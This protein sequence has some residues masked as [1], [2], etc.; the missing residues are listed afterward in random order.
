[1][2]KMN[3]WEFK[4]CGRETASSGPVC[5]AARETRLDSIHGGRNAGRACWV[6]S[7]TCCQGEEQGSFAKKSATCEK[8]DF[9]ARVREEEGARFQLSIVLLNRLKD[10][11]S[12]VK[13][14]SRLIGLPVNSPRKGTSV[15]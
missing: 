13:P 4:K 3:C 9:Q 12:A 8:C 7:G 1:M 2:Q 5:P 15:P 10:T 11:D 14:A 6:V